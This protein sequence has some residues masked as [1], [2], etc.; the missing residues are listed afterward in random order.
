MEARAA[1]VQIVRDGKGGGALVP[2]V[3]KGRWMK[4]R[5]AWYDAHREAACPAKGLSSRWTS[6][7]TAGMS[8]GEMAGTKARL[9]E[10]R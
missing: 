10:R 8:L 7:R 2:A 3:M 4:M 6:Y 9:T 1:L 5:S